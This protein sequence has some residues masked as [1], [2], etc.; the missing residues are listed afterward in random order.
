MDASAH[1]QPASLQIL[2]D[3]RGLVIGRLE[4]RP[5]GKIVARDAHGLLVR[6]YDPREGTTRDGL[7]LV[8]AQSDVLAALLIRR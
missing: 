7:V 5:T 1:H 3:R 8:V 6:T 2:R 4:Q